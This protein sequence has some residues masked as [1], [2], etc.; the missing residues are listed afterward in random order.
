TVHDP[1]PADD[2]EVDRNVERGCDL[3]HREG[4]REPEQK[5]ADPA[6]AEAGRKPVFRVDEFLRPRRGLNL[7]ADAHFRIEPSI[8]R[9]G[10]G[11]TFLAAKD[12]AGSSPGSGAAR[13]SSGSR[14]GWTGEGRP[15]RRAGQTRIREA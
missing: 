14:N 1:E 13:P 5:G 3:K 10:H 15:R 8:I 2:L 7:G 9:L 4:Q 6:A 12:I 11:T